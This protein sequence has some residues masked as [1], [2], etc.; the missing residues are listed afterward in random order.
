[1]SCLPAA[2]V[3][4][5]ILPVDCVAPKLFQVRYLSHSQMS[6]ENGKFWALALASDNFHNW[7]VFRVFS[8][9]ISFIPIEVFGNLMA[10]FFNTIFL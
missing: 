3:N 4:P 10:S 9:I 2:V 5:H 8:L 1:M 6:L 7:K